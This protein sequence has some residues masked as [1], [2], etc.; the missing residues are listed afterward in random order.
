MATTAI[1]AAPTLVDGSTSATTTGPTALAGATYAVADTVTVS[2][3]A[4]AGANGK[5]LF[6]H[7]V[8]TAGTLTLKAPT[9]AA[10]GLGSAGPYHRRAGGDVTITFPGTGSFLTT[11]EIGKWADANGLITMVSGTA[12]GKVQVLRVPPA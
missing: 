3:S 12:A 4:L 2:A 10:A 9:V 5:L 1:T 11:V 8:T 7:T 6:Y